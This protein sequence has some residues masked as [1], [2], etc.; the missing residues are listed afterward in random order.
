MVEENKSGPR[1]GSID[2]YFGG[3][4]GDKYHL[5]YWCARYIPYFKRLLDEQ[6]TTKNI[7]EIV[8]D[9]PPRGYEM[10]PVIVRFAELR[11]KYSLP[12]LHDQLPENCTSCRDVFKKTE[13]EAVNKAIDAFVEFADENITIDA[14]EMMGDFSRL[15]VLTDLATHYEMSSLVSLLG[16]VSAYRLQVMPETDFFG[17]LNSLQSSLGL[18]ME[19]LNKLVESVTVSTRSTGADNGDED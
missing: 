19:S 6:G 13:D 3:K 5:S 16:S 15:S 12:D 14:D 7:K 2:V 1:T 11:C 9:D 4:D 10:F 17:S 8:V 18:D